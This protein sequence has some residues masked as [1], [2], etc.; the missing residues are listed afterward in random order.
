[1]DIEVSA[2]LVFNATGRGY[3][4]FTPLLQEGFAAKS[5][6]DVS[7]NDLLQG[8]FGLDPAYIEDRIKTV[9]LEGKPVDDFDAV[10]VRDGG[11]LALSAAMPGLVGAVMRKGGILSPFRSAISHTGS[12]AAACRREGH[13]VI[14]LFNL[15]P[16]EIGQVFMGQGIYIRPASAQRF[17]S[18]QP[19]AF[20][21]SCR[22]ARV[23]GRDVPPERLAHQG[24]SGLSGHVFIR[25]GD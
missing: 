6:V 22:S 7:I 19:G 1:M 9:F 15:L 2:G 10:F 11:T 21:Q 18:L 23:N 14:K 3:Q 16:G 20:W 8:Q 12:G 13:L 24:W 17:F 4:A 5:C 25:M